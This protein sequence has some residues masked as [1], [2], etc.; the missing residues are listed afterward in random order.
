MPVAALE[1]KTDLTGRKLGS[2]RYEV[3]RRLGSGSMGHVFVA[4]DSRLKTDVV[5]KVPT[6]ARLEKEEYRRRFMKESEFLVKLNHPHV[7]NVLDVDQVE[8]TGIPYFVMPYIGGG[9]LSDRLELAKMS[10]SIG[11]DLDELSDWLRPIAQALDFL[12]DQK[13]IHRDVKPGNILFDN[14]GN[15]FLSDFG[16]SKLLAEEQCDDSSQTAAGSVV[17]TPNY[18]APELVLGHKYDGRAD[19]YSLAITVFEVLSGKAPFEGPTASATMVNQTTKRA[20]LISEIRPE[21]PEKCAQALSRG[22]AKKASNRFSSCKEFA[23]AIL[24][25]TSGSGAKQY[26]GFGS[27]DTDFATAGGAQYTVLKTSK[28]KPGRVPCPKCKK[29]LIIKKEHASRIGRCAQ[30]K[31]KVR[32]GKGLDTLKLLKQVSPSSS[33]QSSDDTPILSTDVFGHRLTVKQAIGLAASLA[34]ILIL[35][36]IWLTYYFSRPEPEKPK[37]AA[38]REGQTQQE[39]RE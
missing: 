7:V 18:V 4:F 3:T 2:G 33:S 21:I 9:C 32:I 12:H 36:A 31:S 26:G 28:G 22:M 1:S 20:P 39:S 13:C 35:V 8:D 25:F 5:I 15:P 19:Q 38:D 29:F 14:H 10:G 37:G 6:L 23:D 30:C 27:G 34:L 11:L 24:E 16:L 17:G